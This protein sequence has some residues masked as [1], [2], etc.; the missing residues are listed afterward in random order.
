MGEYLIWYFENLQ[1]F[2]KH[3][4]DV[5]NSHLKRGKS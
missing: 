5:F 3:K 4:I 1:E 2:Y